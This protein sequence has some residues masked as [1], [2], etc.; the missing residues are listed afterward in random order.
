MAADDSSWRDQLEGVREKFN[1]AV[2]ALTDA[3]ESFKSAKLA[4]ETIAV[5]TPE[6]M[7]ILIDV[8]EAQRLLA[9]SRSAVYRLIEANRLHP[10]K[11]FGSMRLRR[12]EVEEFT[13]TEE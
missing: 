5:G 4:M 2:N 6:G 13:G 1:A 12:K 3:V 8:N 11:V 9:I 10:V 7:P